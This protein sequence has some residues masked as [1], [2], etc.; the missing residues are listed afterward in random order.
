MPLDLR[1]ISPKIGKNFFE[2]S[3][4]RYDIIDYSI[5]MNLQRKISLLNM[6]KVVPID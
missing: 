1:K 6:Q 5:T 3:T 4:F 2:Q